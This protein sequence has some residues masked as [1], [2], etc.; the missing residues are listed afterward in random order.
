VCSLTQLLVWLLVLFLDNNNNRRNN[1]SSH[2][3]SNRH[4]NEMEGCEVVAEG[5]E[6][7]EGEVEG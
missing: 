2:H 5:R 1:S 3:N 7:A 4:Q 6:E